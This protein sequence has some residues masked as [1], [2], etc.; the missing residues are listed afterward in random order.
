MV[1]VFDAK[2]KHLEATTTKTTKP[3]GHQ[4]PMNQIQISDIKE[5]TKLF[6]LHSEEV[7]GVKRM[8]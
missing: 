8:M 2:G 6:K 3:T 4:C 7:A 1:M 5:L